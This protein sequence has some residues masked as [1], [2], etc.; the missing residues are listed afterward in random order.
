[1]LCVFSDISEHCLQQREM[2]IGKLKSLYKN[3]LPIEPPKKDFKPKHPQLPKLKSY[4]MK[5]PEG[6]WEK[7][8]ENKQCPAES[9]IDGDMLRKLALEAGYK[10]VAQLEKVVKYLKEGVEIGCK[11]KYRQ[12]S[13]ARNAP[14]AY[15]AGYKVTDAICDW[16][17]KGFAYGPVKLSE[18][19]KSAKISSIMTRPKPNG[20]VRIILNLSAPKGV[21]VNDGIDVKEYPTKMS[22]TT[23][24]LRVLK[25]AGKG[26]VFLKVDWADAYKHISVSPEDTDL[27]WFIWMDRAFKELCLIFG[28]AS[29]PGIFDEV[30][31]IVLFIVAKRAGFPMGLIIQH[32]DDC[33]AAAS[34]SKMA[35]LMKLD[36]T[37]F[38]VAELLGLRLASREDPDKSFGPSQIGT[39]LGVSYNTK[40]WT[41][42]I[43]EEKLARLRLDIA[44]VLKLKEI[45][46]EDM[47]S[48]CGKLIHYK[49]LIPGGK[50]HIDHILRANGYSGDKRAR[51]PM[52]QG[53]YDQL[54][55]WYYVLELCNG[56]IKIPNPDPHLAPWA[57][58]VFTD[59]AGGS[60]S[61]NWHGVGAVTENWWAYAPWGQKINTG[62]D[63]GEGRQ[64][65]RVMSAL[66]LLGP[67]LTVSAGFKWCMNNHIRV[68]VDNQA[69]V[70]IFAKGYSSACPLSSTLAKAIFTVAAGLGCRIEVKKITRCST[71]LAN[72][73]DSLSKGEFMRFW[74]QCKEEE[75]NLPL[76]MAWVPRELLR[77]ILDPKEDDRLGQKIL[78]ELSA[79]VPVLGLW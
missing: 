4:V 23:Q 48:I 65:D 40:D 5:A 31:K 29:S 67:L 43:P 56:G 73:A 50:F 71:P 30:A 53:L 68:W 52:N 3:H 17:D 21:S 46:Q 44:K 9:L 13:K 32:L 8:P 18:V 36:K 1:M 54:E 39:V 60:Y 26:C 76:D 35:D 51:V 22:S 66:E 24:W 16:V 20:S 77:W 47:W 45:V 75:L 33:C 34:K 72:M 63:A 58:E 64:L 78:L 11:G 57:V 49:P 25:K 38:E 6:F 62:Q 61:A 14:S 7:F 70:F 79:F 42:C 74:S 19:P 37:F 27:Q 28:A 10:D 15:A 55:F 2:W 41:W 12:P 69:S 59:A